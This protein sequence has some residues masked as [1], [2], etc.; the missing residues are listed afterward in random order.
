MLLV[1]F[2]GYDDFSSDVSPCKIPHRFRQFTQRVSFIDDERHSP[3]SKS[4][5]QN[6]IVFVVW[7]PLPD[8]HFLAPDP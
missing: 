2:E 6:Q 1:M 7:F 8:S 5:Q 4:R 3:A